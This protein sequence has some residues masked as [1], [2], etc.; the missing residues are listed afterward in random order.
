M[1]IERTEPPRQDRER[2]VTIDFASTYFR[3]SG[4]TVNQGLLDLGQH[5]ALG[6]RRAR[7][8]IF[9]TRS[10]LAKTFFNGLSFALNLSE[11]HSARS[12]RLVRIIFFSKIAYFFQRRFF[13]VARIPR[14]TEFVEARSI[15]CNPLPPHNT[16]DRLPTRYK[17]ILGSSPNSPLVPDSWMIVQL[18]SLGTRY[19]TKTNVG[20]DQLVNTA[21]SQTAEM[22]LFGIIES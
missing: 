4:N 7:L 8:E 21:S 22:N 18:G 2:S 17:V 6:I 13:G 11:R 15:T 3:T 1:M 9:K 12:S 5:L 20:S 10:V 19:P 14:T 16:A